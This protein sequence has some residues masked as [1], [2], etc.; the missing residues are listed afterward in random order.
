MT[1]EKR[2]KLI[3]LLTDSTLFGLD[4]REAAEL[5]QLKQQFPEWEN[6]VSF[7]LAAAA[8][9]LNNLDT[10]QE[11]P[12]NVRARVLAAADD[13]FGDTKDARNVVSFPVKAGEVA[14]SGNRIFE[15][16]NAPKQPFWQWFGWGVA[17]LAC[18]ALAVN[19]WT[20][21]SRPATE[22]VDKPRVEQTPIP[23]LTDAQKREQLL[24]TATDVVKTDW[25][26]PKD[27]KQ[28][29]GDIV[30]S[31]ERQTGYMRFRGLPANNRERE[32]Y[33]LWIVDETQ[34]PKTPVSGGVFDVDENGE[35]VVPIN[36][37]IR[38]RQPKVFAVTKEKSG[39]VVVSTQKEFVAVA[40]I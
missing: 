4:E 30:W 3:E 21:S 40:K 6:D 8:I 5:N 16:S 13:F 35:A 7:E 23:E 37:Q 36:A 22:I 38:V 2:E 20:T 18:V 10:N 39:G 1:D 17:A 29:L 9:N 27:D 11:L 26:S 19:L 25:K 32:S 15:E 14:A 31:G 28:I 33:Q 34:N 12:A 24:A